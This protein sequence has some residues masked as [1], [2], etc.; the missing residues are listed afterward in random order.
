MESISH[1]LLYRI[2]LTNIKWVGSITARNLLNAVDGDEAK[3]FSL[4]KK[5]L[6][7]IEG[8]SLRLA[9]EILNPEVLRRSEEEVRFVEK[10][11]LKTFF[12]TDNDYPARL[13]ECADAPMVLYHKGNVNLNADKVMSIVGTRHAT[14]YGLNYCDKFLQEL[15]SVFPDLLVISGL[16]YGVDIQ[17]HRC[18]LKY[19]LPTVAVLA[20]GLDRIYPHV[21][22]KT[23]IEMLDNGGLLSDYKSGTEPERYNFVS[24]NRIVAGMADAVIVVESGARGGSLI[25]A[26]LANSYCKDVFATPGRVGD[27]GSI[28]CNKLIADHKADLL[29][30]TEHF[31]H[32]MGWDETS[33]I[34]KHAPQQQE[35]FVSLNSEEQVVVDIL[36]KQGNIHIDLLAHESNMPVHQLLSTLLEMELKGVVRNIPGNVVTLA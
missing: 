11:N 4:S 27:K 36:R 2:A 7:Q 10:N 9:D 32:Q 13:R 3:L 22:R 30:S 16:A 23:A 24:R 15:S 17:A 6:L 29:L 5:E 8:I 33:K 31:I 25:T 35:L 21:H 19:N 26:E 20:H 18:A 1:K 34:K 12:I 28:G 14:D